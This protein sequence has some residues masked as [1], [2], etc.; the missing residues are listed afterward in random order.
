LGQ[1]SGFGV[2]IKEVVNLFVVDLETG[3]EKG[4]FALKFFFQL[5]FLLEKVLNSPRNYPLGMHWLLLILQFIHIFGF[6]GPFH[7]VGLS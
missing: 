5:L 2:E 7:G 3:D 6:L 4:K 1:L